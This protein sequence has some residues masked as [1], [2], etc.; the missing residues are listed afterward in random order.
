MALLVPA[1]LLLL[2]VVLQAALVARDS[3]H[4]VRA[5]SA[6]ARAAM[7]HPS[8]STARDALAEV[9]AGL[10]VQGLT[11]S[12]GRDPGSLLTVSVVARPTRLPVVGV[13]LSTVRLRE[14]LTV[15]VEG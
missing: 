1:V 4:L 12:G 10:D 9:G 2:L 6:A 7:V 15:R 13:A 11:L 3:V 8:Q 5:T 14:S